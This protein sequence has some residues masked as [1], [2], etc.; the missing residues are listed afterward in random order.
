M[1]SRGRLCEGHRAANL[2]ENDVTE[3][4]LFEKKDRIAM[5]TLNRADRLNRL[6]RQMADG[7]AEMCGVIEDDAEVRVVILTA[8]GPVFS[9]GLDARA[10]SPEEWRE[11][12]D[13]PAES[14]RHRHW[15]LYG[16]EAVASL[17]K[18]VIAALNGDALGAGLELALAC[19][20]RVSRED[21]RFGFPQV[22]EG[23]IPMSGGTQ[24]LPRI[25]GLAKALELIM[26]GE[27]IDAHEARRIGLV[28]RV[29]LPNELPKVTEEL[30]ASILKGAPLAV[31]YGKE[32]VRQG[33]DLSF[34]EGARLEA[35]LSLLLHTTADRAEGIRSFQEKRNPEFHGR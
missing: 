12:I 9:L 31:R 18:P 35:D 13:T 29:V 3:P 1:T 10:V 4:I 26:T 32:A 16:V 30:A 17:S 22:R 15:A 19:D 25:I 11:L 21:A 14:V 5:I 28:G 7:L 20:I 24:R 2:M 34:V 23:M 8:A 27:P 33:T 6:T